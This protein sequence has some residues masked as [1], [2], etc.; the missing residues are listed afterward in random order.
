MPIL[1]PDMTGPRRRPR[2]VPPR[3]Q[4]DHQHHLDLTLSGRNKQA[5]A[6][7]ADGANAPRQNSAA[8][9]APKRRHL[10][11]ARR[12]ADAAGDQTLTYRRQPEDAH[13]EGDDQIAAL[14]VEHTCQCK[15]A[16]R[17]AR[18]P[19]PQPEGMAS[20][21]T[22]RVSRKDAMRRRSGRIIEG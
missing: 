10:A 1:N 18:L 5:V 15:L 4:E 21:S 7:P 11:C 17:G 13:V 3:N 8:V 16:A 22:L 2:R 14:G 12:R 20:R 6:A 9:W 19:D